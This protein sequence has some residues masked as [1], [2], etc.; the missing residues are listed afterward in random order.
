[1]QIVT[2]RFY[3]KPE[4]ADE[5]PSAL[6]ELTAAT[7]NEPGNLWYLW[8]RSLDDPNEYVV[9]EGYTD[10]GFAAHATSEHFRSGGALI[11]PFLARTPD[12]I[13]RQVEGDGWD[14]LTVLA[15]D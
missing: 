2:V 1:M 8:S 3:V 10:D 14:Q 6:T 7:R 4:L 12:I 11:H 9:I 5:F 15:V 13:A